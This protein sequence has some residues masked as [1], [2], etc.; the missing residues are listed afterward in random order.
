M[1]DEE[2]GG[3]TISYSI[4]E[5]LDGI[6]TS[7]DRIYVKLDTKADRSELLDL[8]KRVNHESKRVDVLETTRNVEAR[9]EDNNREW[10]KWLIPSILTLAM[11]VVSVIQVLKSGK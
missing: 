2:N 10:T 11:L 3:G 1:A 9:N 8:A 7:I 6:K 4:K 5:L